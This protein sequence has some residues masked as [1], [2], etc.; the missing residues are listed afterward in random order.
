MFEASSIAVHTSPLMS[1]DDLFAWRRSAGRTPA[2]Q[3][4]TVLA[5]GTAF[6]VWTSPPV[7]RALPLLLVNGGL[8]YGHDL[9]WPAL[10]PL[11]LGRQIILYDQRGRGETPAPALP[12]DARLEDDAADIGPLRRA[13]GIRRWDL[14]GHSWG[15]VI[16]LLGAAHDLAGTRRVVTVDAVGPTSDWMPELHEAV[17][18]SASEGDAATL[19]ELGGTPLHSDD[20]VTHARYAAAGYRSWFVHPSFRD[21]F[22]P[23]LSESVVGAAIAARLRREGYDWRPALR[24][25]SAPVLVMHGEGDA[26]P[27]RVAHELVSLLPDARLQLIPEAG[28]MPFLEQPS[29]FFSAVSS[30]LDA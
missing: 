11:A 16:A 13:L 14:L 7:E 28:H 10:A 8:L 4:M 12:A 17:L 6:A 1:R 26:M 27:V 23:P 5:R 29:H 9:L 3:R 19:R 21:H 15:G 24:A 18:A 2:L 20:P 30:F 22:T 25:L